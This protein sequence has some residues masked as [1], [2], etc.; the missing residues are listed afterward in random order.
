MVYTA[1]DL[2]R[3]VETGAP[4]GNEVFTTVTPDGLRS[5]ESLSPREEGLGDR[6]DCIDCLFSR[7]RYSAALATLCSAVSKIDRAALDLILML[8]FPFKC[9]KP[10]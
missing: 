3:E 8:E 7:G 6:L 1:R 2:E 9:D 5:S 10:P 4:R